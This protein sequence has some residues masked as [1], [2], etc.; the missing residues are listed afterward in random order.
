MGYTEAINERQLEVANY[1]IHVGQCLYINNL[2]VYSLKALLNPR[3]CEYT[4]RLG[5]EA[6]IIR[7]EGEGPEFLQDYGDGDGDVAYLEVDEMWLVFRRTDEIE[8]ISCKPHAHKPKPLTCYMTEYN[9]GEPYLCV[10]NRQGGTEFFSQD[11]VHNSAVLDRDTIQALT[12][13]VN[14]QF[15]LDF[16]TTMDELTGPDYIVLVDQH[17]QNRTAAEIAKASFLYPKFKITNSRSA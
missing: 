10:V 15:V 13:P 3:K 2:S 6:F 16:G 8:L 4:I 12:N 9:G 17:T 7:D 14:C 5:N 11:S 1:P